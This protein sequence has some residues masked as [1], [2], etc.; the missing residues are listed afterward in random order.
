[1]AFVV[2]RDIPK[3]VVQLDLTAF[4]VGGGFRGFANA[5]EG[6]HHLKVRDGERWVFG[7]VW[8]E[9][10][11]AAAVL[12]YDEGRLVADDPDEA[13]RFAQLAGSGAMSAAL[14]DALAQPDAP[15]RALAWREATSALDRPL[16][17][18]GE[19]PALEGAS[20]FLAFIEG[21]GG[22]ARAA[23]REVQAAFMRAAARDD[24]AAATRLL[25]VLAGCFGAGERNVT[26]HAGFFEGF[27]P[28]VAAML[29]L[30]P[31]LRGAP[32][33]ATR[34]HLVE[35]LADAGLTAAADRLRGA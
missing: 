20:R 7:E 6:Y 33:L 32:Q 5:L 29:T 24:A 28:T 13:A 16:D 1:M 23:L 19:G 34:E 27:A 15:A 2:L 25:A 18:V 31:V 21:H 17:E 10:P 35:D 11:G 22:D 12:R 3:D 26:A 4:R 14:I 30:T 8:L 9:R